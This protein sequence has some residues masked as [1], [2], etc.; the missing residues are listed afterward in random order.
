MHLRDANKGVGQPEYRLPL[1]VI[2][3]FTLP[4]AIFSYG[5]ITH[6]RLP[7]VFLLASVGLMGFT[8]TLAFMP[9]MAF[10]VDATGLF[11]ASA[12][13]GL[14]VTRCLMGT[15]LPLTTAPL[16][17][18]LGYGWGFTILAAVCLVTAPIPSLIMRYGP[19]WRSSSKYTRGA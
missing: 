18:N 17:G 16:I 12:M 11:S 2:G 4:L 6:F 14:I 19:K 7:L 15:F 13:T 8:F 9:L 3:G 5:W 1:A 10:V